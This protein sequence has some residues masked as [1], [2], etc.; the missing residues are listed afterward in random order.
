MVNLPRPGVVNSRLP[1]CRERYQSVD[2]VGCDA[3]FSWQNIKTKSES[4]SQWR[5]D[6]HWLITEQLWP[7]K[8]CFHCSYTKSLTGCFTWMSSDVTVCVSLWASGGVGWSPGA[9]V[10][11]VS[12]P[13]RTHLL[14]LLVFHMMA[15]YNDYLKND[16][17]R[18]WS[19][20]QRGRLICS[21]HRTRKI[22]KRKSK[23]PAS[24]F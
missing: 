18:E 22:W 16:C 1:T 8:L 7:E 11:A 14:S 20:L 24:P 12:E 13:T 21:V 5:R 9:C 19:S 6:K 4:R 3:Y 17:E 15:W 23:S 10:C 2:V